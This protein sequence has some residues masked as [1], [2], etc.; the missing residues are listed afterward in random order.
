MITS[1]DIKNI[2]IDSVKSNPILGRIKEIKPDKH[3]PVSKG[4]A[5]ERI[6]VLVNAADDSSWKHTY[7]RV[8]VYVPDEKALYDEDKIYLKPNEER[9]GFLEKECNEL[10]HR[11]K[12]LEINN[13]T[14]YYELASGI[15]IE[16]DPE[17]W[18]HFINVYLKV[19]NQNFKL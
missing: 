10:F 4:N 2:L 19:T 16:E 17:T 9:I 6:V 3:S 8:C 15:I 14:L 13:Q 18:S 1:T 11:R 12:L 7:A 5:Q